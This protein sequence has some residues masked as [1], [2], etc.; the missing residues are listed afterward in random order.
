MRNVKRTL[1]LVIALVMLLGMMTIGAGA[2]FTDE[3][4]IDYVEA[5]SV[6]NMAGIIKGYPDGSF[7]SE[8]VLNRA[9]AAVM[10]ARLLG[11]DDPSTSSSF[12]DVHDVAQW[13]WAEGAI[14]ICEVEGIL[15]GN[16][17]GTFG[18]ADKLTGY[19]WA[20]MLLCAIGYD[21]AA[22]G[23]TGA[24][25]DNG[26]YKLLKS[27]QLSKGVV[28]F[29]GSDYVTREVA[30]QMAFAAAQVATRTYTKGT[31]ITGT[32][33]TI[34]VGGSYT[35]TNGPTLFASLGVKKNDLAGTDDFGRPITTWYVDADNDDTQDATEK[36]AEVAKT[37]GAKYVVTK[38][39]TTAAAII[40]ALELNAEAIVGT[41]NI[42]DLVEFYNNDADA[43]LD[44]AIAT[45]Q[46]LYQVSKVTAAA[47]GAKYDYTVAFK[48][49]ANGNANGAAVVLNSDKIEGYDAAT[50]AKDAYVLLTF[51][52][53]G[54]VASA[55]LATVAATGKV[56]AKGTGYFKLDGA[57][58]TYANG[59][60]ALAVDSTKSYNVF[61]N[62]DG[63]VV[64]YA[65]VS[66]APA[67]TAS[68]I[69]NIVDDQIE[70]ASGVFGADKAK[71]AVQYLDGTSAI[72]EMKIS[73]VSGAKYV[74]IGG[75]NV[76]LASADAAIDTGFYAYTADETG[77]ITNVTAVTV[78]GIDTNGDKKADAAIAATDIDFDAK[79]AL[80]KVDTTT[81]LYATDATTVTTINTTT[82]KTTV[83]TGYAN[84][85]DKTYAASA[86]AI[87]VTY[88]GST[89]NAVYV[90]DGAAMTAA[91]AAVYG[92]YI[93]TGDTYKNAAGS[94]V[95]DVVYNVAGVNTTYTIAGESVASDLKKMV[96][97]E[98]TNG[99]AALTEYATTEYAVAAV[100]AD[101]VVFEGVAAPVYLAS[102]VK[103]YDATNV[104]KNG[105]VAA[106]GIAKGDIV[107]Y[108]TNAQSKITAAYVVYA[109]KEDGLLTANNATYLEKVL[110]FSAPDAASLIA[111]GNK[112]YVIKM[113][114]VAK[115]AALDTYYDLKLIVTDAAGAA[116]EITLN[117]LATGNAIMFDMTGE[118]AGNWT[119]AVADL[120]DAGAIIATG[121]FV[122]A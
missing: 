60:T 70:A 5:A 112:G 108:M 47:E 98:V 113:T 64:G 14:G 82:G 94:Y 53:G 40:K 85:A 48:G 72:V 42:G 62:A 116:Q 119:Y 63:Y 35:E 58:Y 95:T 57:Q 110:K 36:T 67:A 49:V 102:G 121:S 16:G 115:V 26:V 104:A 122:V 44:I 73:T 66:A 96:T 50:M 93:S 89:L 33:L 99:I 24:N 56:T 1:A 76:A 52:A 51:N 79:S 81:A 10:I 120:N 12:T 103:Y 19:A 38:N 39:A 118:A 2:A 21:A 117:D 111:A 100:Y 83:V 54:T 109:A 31:T 7:G 107:V 32:G 65:L 8:V 37:A 46:K 97:I 43:K 6:M 18:P 91:P 68:Q 41:Y 15:L 9:E 30:A 88:S 80:V 27:V 11:F 69:F 105:I 61:T 45:T 17:D 28:G 77:L 13:A 25:W 106:D 4:D 84:F 71:L 29:D 55:E 22:E 78:A 74:K 20:K 90:L 86:G 23:M 59:V 87:L 101:Y 3:A 114:S 75:E 92:W 34:D